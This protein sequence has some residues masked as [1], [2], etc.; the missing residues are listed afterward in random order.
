MKYASYRNS[1]RW[2]WKCGKVVVNRIWTAF[3]ARK[4]WTGT[5]PDLWA[6]YDDPGETSWKGRAFH[7]F[8]KLLTVVPDL[9]TGRFVER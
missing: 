2:R 9:F 5:G 3:F 8:H 4:S 7:G 1:S 6:G